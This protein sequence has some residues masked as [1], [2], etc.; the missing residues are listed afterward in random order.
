MKGSFSG[1]RGILWGPESKVQRCGARTRRT[2]RPCMRPSE[3]NPLTG[4]RSRCR[5]HGGLAG[6]RTPEGKA[7][8]AAAHTTH[9]RYTAV[10][11]AERRA[12]FL[13]ER[14]FK[15]FQRQSLANIRMENAQLQKELRDEQRRRTHE[16]GSAR[17]VF[18]V[19]E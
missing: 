15:A 6:P 10:A 16:G 3:I 19:T 14:A 5:L 17:V 18:P 12:A 7:R 9:G 1:R 11:K 8:I 13:K 4:R 2:G